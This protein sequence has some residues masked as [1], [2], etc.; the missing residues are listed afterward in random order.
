M[1]DPGGTAGTRPPNRINFFCFC[2]PFHRK[3][4][5]SEVAP[6]PTGRRPAPMGN[7]GSA[8]GNVLVMAPIS[9][10]P[11]VDPGFPV[12]RHL[13]LFPLTQVIFGD[14]YVKTKELGPVEGMC[15]KFLHVDPP[16]NALHL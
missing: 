14:M 12:G 15:L 3:V 10:I 16:L 7:P 11:G 8:T 5:A 6:P 13:P 1:A 2:I 9:V 4:Y